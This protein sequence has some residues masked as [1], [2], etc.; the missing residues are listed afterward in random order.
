MSTSVSCNKKKEFKLVTDFFTTIQLSEV[1]TVTG[2]SLLK[3]DKLSQLKMCLDEKLQTL[4]QL[5]EKIVEPV[6]EENLKLG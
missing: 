6:P 1:N 2:A 3:G 4:K 5:D